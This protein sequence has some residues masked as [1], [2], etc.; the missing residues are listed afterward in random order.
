MT[1]VPTPGLGLPPA[2]TLSQN[3]MPTYSHSRIET[4]RHCPRKYF[5]R[6]IA[7]IELPEPPEQ[8]AIVLGS[9][10]HDVL[11]HLY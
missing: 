8:I 6:Y 2:N 11:A 4:F 1:V 9:R 5:F 7:K 3:R 10:V